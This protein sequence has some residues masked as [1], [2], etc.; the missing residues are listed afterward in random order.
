MDQIGIWGSLRCWSSAIHS[1]FPNFVFASHLLLEMFGSPELFVFSC[2]FIRDSRRQAGDLCL[3]TECPSHWRLEALLRGL[4]M[5]DSC[6]VACDWQ[7]SV[8]AASVSGAVSPNELCTC[9]HAILR[10][11]CLRSH[12]LNWAEYWMGA[13]RSYLGVRG[14]SA[15]GLDETQNQV[16]DYSTSPGLIIAQGIICAL[17]NAPCTFSVS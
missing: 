2:Q 4:G 15:A 3:A 7:S 8:P 10:C 6:R 11:D 17:L 13:L 5:S 9:C 16:P 14:G 1:R 12:R